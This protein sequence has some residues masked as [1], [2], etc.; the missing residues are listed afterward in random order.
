MGQSLQADLGRIRELRRKSV[1]Q[2]HSRLESHRNQITELREL[3]ASLEE[4]RIWLKQ[5]ARIN[6][7][8]ST[9]SRALQKWSKE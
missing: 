5:N 3:H 2:R 9:I 6:I 8:I 1:R 4:I 7:S